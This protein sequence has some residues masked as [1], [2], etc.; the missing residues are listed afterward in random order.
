M[1]K[2]TLRALAGASFLCL[3]MASF[4]EEDFQP[5]DELFQTELVFPQEKGEFQFV[6]SPTYIQHDDGE[7]LLL[8]ITFEYGFTKAFQIEVEWEALVRRMPDQSGNK[9]GSGNLG[10]GFKYAWMDID[11]AGL[12]I[13]IGY[14]HTFGNGDKDV[15]EDTDED[16]LYV[17]IAKDLDS[18]A[19]RQIMIQIGIEAE[20]DE[21]ESFVNLAYY[22]KQRDFV[23]AAEYNWSEEE[24]YI[25]PGIAFQPADEWEVGVG[26][27]LG[28]NDEADDF[29]LISNIG[30]EFD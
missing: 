6:L 1:I 11:R 21:D 12:N 4:A 18:W 22:S 26:L 14:E 24:R 16:E 15:V 5:I 13:A 23:W 20:D 9:S 28:I 17:I 27:A 19:D 2:Q 30:F 8:P 10:I 7:S 29:L 3:S 25:T